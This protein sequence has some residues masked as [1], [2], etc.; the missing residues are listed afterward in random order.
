MAVFSEAMSSSRCVFAYLSRN[1]KYTVFHP[2]TI[3]RNAHS[4]TCESS[5]NYDIIVTGGGI[6]GTTLACALG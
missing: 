2:C 4:A 1:Y 5:E 6:V 3:V